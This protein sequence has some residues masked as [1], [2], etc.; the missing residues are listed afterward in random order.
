MSNLPNAHSRE[1]ILLKAIAESQAIDS[2]EPKS[3]VE[4]YLKQIMEN[5]SISPE[6]I[7][8]AVDAY[9]AEYPLEMDASLVDPLKAAPA[10]VVGERLSELKSDIADF[11]SYIEHTDGYKEY[12]LGEPDA[13]YYWNGSLKSKR[14]ST[15]TN[16]FR[17]YE[18]ISVKAGKYDFKNIS[19]LFTFYVDSD[20]WIAFG[21]SSSPFNGTIVFEYDTTLYI[22]EKTYNDGFHGSE[23]TSGAYGTTEE[24]WFNNPK[25]DI[26]QMI[27]E[28]TKTNH[29]YVSPVGSD[30]NGD[31]S[32]DNPFATMYHAN[33]TITD[34]SEKNQYI[35]HVADGTYT[36]LQSR[37][38]GSTTHENFEGIICKPWVIYE[39]NVN[40]PEN[41]VIQWNG[42]T[43]Y[44]DDFDYDNHA[45]H[46]CPFHITSKGIGD[47][48][49]RGFT[50][51]CMNTRYALH[52]EIAGYGYGQNWL[53]SDCNFIWGGTPDCPGHTYQTPCIGTGSGQF[54]KGHLLR[55]KIINASGVTDAFRNHDSRWVLGTKLGNVPH[56]GAEIILEDCVFNAGDSG[57]TNI[58]FR[59]IYEDG[60]V[61][62]YNRFSIINCTGINRLGYS[63]SGN[64]TKCDWRANVKCSDITNN[65]FATE[66]LLQ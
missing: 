9:L 60:L 15:A 40:H 2:P 27:S 47:K 43:G 56:V 30:A 48:I 17:C 14:L 28:M 1:E 66:G 29:L 45:V 5:G 54:E 31:G 19:P 65:V 39:G 41:V 46:F 22:T 38:Q 64:A 49:V 51:D 7:Q 26:E 24:N 6:E 36:D 8:A 58:T 44:G 50:F 21:T 61:D 12:T 20:T 16:T 10:G 23:L 62:G 37:Y 57:D 18:P 55:C 4:I 3:R 11:E 59:N 34:A 33:E 52:V 32:K 25:Y 53:V 42:K 63:L 13:D 35:I